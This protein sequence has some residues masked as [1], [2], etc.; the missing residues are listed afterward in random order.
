M[1]GRTT[2][3]LG[4]GTQPGGARNAYD[5]ADLCDDGDQHIQADEAMNQLCVPGEPAVNRQ[6]QVPRDV[7]SPAH[8][9]G[10][11]KFSRHDVKKALL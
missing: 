2:A 7:V 10:Y 4:P 9:I 6:H 5:M 3:G 8:K 1:A 11:V